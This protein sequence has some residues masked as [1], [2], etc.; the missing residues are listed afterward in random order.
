MSAFKFDLLNSSA[1]EFQYQCIEFDES[2]IKGLMAVEQSVAIL[3]ELRW[4]W[5]EETMFSNSFKNGFSRTFF[6]HLFFFSLSSL[7]IRWKEDEIIVNEPRTGVSIKIGKITCSRDNYNFTC[8]ALL[9]PK[10]ER[11]N[12]SIV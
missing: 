11:R 10:H 4:K 2:I 6:F 8:A 7:P 3:S 12:Y 9:H 5:V 1:I